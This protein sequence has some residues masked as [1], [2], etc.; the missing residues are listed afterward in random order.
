MLF[1]TDLIICDRRD[2]T[3]LYPRTRVIGKGLYGIDAHTNYL[4]GE[5][6]IDHQYFL[7]GL[8]IPLRINGNPNVSDFLAKERVLGVRLDGAPKA[9]PF[10]AMGER[11]VIND[12]VGV[13]DLAV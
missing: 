3:T 5:N 1:N 8:V 4:Y 9:Y 2:G 11:A 13:V 10:S 6:C 7:F 12:Q